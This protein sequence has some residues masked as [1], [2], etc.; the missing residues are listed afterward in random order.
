MEEV[1]NNTE[2]QTNSRL[3]L[4]EAVSQDFPSL[5][6]KSLHNYRQSFGE[7]Y[8]DHGNWYKGE[9]EAEYEQLGYHGDRLWNYAKFIK[10]SLRG[11]D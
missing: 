7:G 6:E 11:E 1:I 2:R 10:E 5:I 4:M 8:P 9:K 3:G